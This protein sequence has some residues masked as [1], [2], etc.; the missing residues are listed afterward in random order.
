MIS[1]IFY[2]VLLTKQFRQT[3]KKPAGE[4]NAKRI[5]YKLLQ[6]PHSSFSRKSFSRYVDK[7]L[8]ATKF[9]CQH[10]LR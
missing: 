3:S 5:K 4:Y 8:P 9:K 7:I 2:I 10:Q 1:T 6:N